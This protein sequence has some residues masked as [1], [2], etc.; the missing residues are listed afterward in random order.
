MKKPQGSWLGGGEGWGGGG[1]G[2]AGGG[3]G[4]WGGW[5]GGPPRFSAL[6]FSAEL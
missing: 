1:G 4:G 3:G 6:R 5:V 2:R